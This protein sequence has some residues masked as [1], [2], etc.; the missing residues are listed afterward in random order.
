MN[1]ILVIKLSKYGFFNLENPTL[2]LLFT[3][4]VLESD[5]QT[6][7]YTFLHKLLSRAME[8]LR[9]TMLV[10]PTLLDGAGSISVFGK[11]LVLY[12]SVVET[13]GSRFK[14]LAQ[15][16]FFLT[17]L[18][19]VG[20]QIDTY[21]DRI[22]AIGTSDTVPSDLLL[23]NLV[24]HIADIREYQPVGTHI[25]NRV[26]TRFDCGQTPNTSDDSPLKI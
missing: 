25:I 11:E 2:N 1:D 4:T 18:R 7:A 23:C 12:Y 21:M 5:S 20:I 13:V 17:S 9:T 6:K 10:P 3:T 16:T 8:Q 24:I 26:N 19:K 15:S 14:P 22:R